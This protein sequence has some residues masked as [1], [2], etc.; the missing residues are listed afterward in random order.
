M[1]A[2]RNLM[3]IAV[4]GLAIAA[5]GKSG[6]D[7]L[8]TIDPS[9]YALGSATAP[10]TLIEYASTS[11]SHCA[12]FNNEVFPAFKA[13]YIDTGQVRYALRE[14]A[15]P[16]TDFAAASF[17]LA[18]CAGPEKYHAVIDA[19]FRSQSAIFQSGDFAG[20][21]LACRD[22]RNQRLEQGHAVAQRQRI[23][24]VHQLANRGMIEVLRLAT[25]RHAPSVYRL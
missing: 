8:S 1:R 3:L 7:T 18:R 20:G 25:R 9:E 5:C 19:V 13:K 2:L 16:P 4:A 6:A 21:N 23:R 15:T 22:L 24:G 14:I 12:R 17:L 10:V 11:C